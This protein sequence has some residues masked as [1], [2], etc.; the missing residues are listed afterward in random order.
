VNIIAYNSKYKAQFKA[1][2]IAWLEKYFYVE[3]YDLEVLS[4]P[5]TYIIDKGGHIF[6]VLDN[7]TPIATVALMPTKE[8]NIYELTKMAVDPDYQGQ[9]L[10]QKLLEYCIAFAKAHAFSGLLLYSNTILEN[11]IYIYRKYGFKEIPL[12]EGVSY[13]RANIKMQ[14]PLK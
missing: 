13:K 9:K 3:P 8:K 1:L 10:G 2:N 11:A 5:E 6:F 14:H 7:E 4:N 12:E